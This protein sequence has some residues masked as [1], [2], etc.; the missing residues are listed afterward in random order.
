VAGVAG[1]Q[2]LPSR[3]RR[4]WRVLAVLVAIALAIVAYT[5]WDDARFVV[6]SVTIT[7]PQV[8]AA[9]DG[10]RIVQITDLHSARFGP[11]QSALLAAV[12]AAKPDLIL[13]TGDYT[14]VVDCPPGTDLTP[15][16]E[17]I[18]GLPAGVPVYYILGNWDGVSDYGG[19]PDSDTALARTLEAKGAKPVY[20]YVEVFRGGAHIWIT[21]WAQTVFR[22]QAAMQQSLA[23]YLRM[24]VRS[25]ERAKAL[26]DAWWARQQRGHDPASEFDV[27]VT[28]RPL[29]FPDYDAELARNA[30]ETASAR[31]AGAAQY[32]SDVDWD[33]NL[34][35]H[36]HGGQFRLPFVG[37][38]ISPE[39]QMF[40]GSR[41]IDGVH[42]D[43]PGRIQYISR[44]LGAGGEI[45]P[46]RF[47]LFDTP[48]FSVIVLHRGAERP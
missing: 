35:G 13:L 22:D 12:A 33:V 10:Y 3:H 44:G 16:T 27:A 40:P 42:A 38:V 19:V 9:F 23:G 41:Y 47:R 36:T 1:I 37:A 24:P 18:S 17:L 30:S 45:R 25:V 15:V 5:E 21:D 11:R 29:D 39:G 6:A 31:A 20:P 7:H 28:H 2:V 32:V 43:E 34:A 14:D 26:Y 8:P 4:A 48:E 46:L